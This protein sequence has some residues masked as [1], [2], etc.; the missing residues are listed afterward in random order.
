MLEEI[1]KPFVD[2][3]IGDGLAHVHA[4]LNDCARLSIPAVVF[5][6]DKTKYRIIGI[7]HFNI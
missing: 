3:E 5:S 4:V 1:P 6:E 7:D 2:K